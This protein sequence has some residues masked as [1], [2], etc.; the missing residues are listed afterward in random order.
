MKCRPTASERLATPPSRDASSKAAEL[1]APAASTTIRA[2]IVLRS[3]AIDAST[4]V[5]RLPSGLKMQPLDARVLAQF[6][7]AVRK[8]LG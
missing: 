3:P 2:E 5:T 4:P 6:D 7:I 8:R 1:T